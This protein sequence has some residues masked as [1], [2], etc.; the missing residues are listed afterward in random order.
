MWIETRDGDGE[1]ELFFKRLER[2]VWLIRLAGL[3]DAEKQIRIVQLLTEIE[4][5][6]KIAAMKALEPDKAIA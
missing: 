2:L 4:A 1:T 3:D 6:N 5:K